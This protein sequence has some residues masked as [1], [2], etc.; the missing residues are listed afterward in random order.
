M[1]KG[2]LI[3]PCLCQEGS[4]QPQSSSFNVLAQSRFF[5]SLCM[6]SVWLLP[7][8]S[9]LFLSFSS[10][11][12]RHTTLTT[13]TMHYLCTTYLSHLHLKFEADYRIRLMDHSDIDGFI[14]HRVKTSAY[15]HRYFLSFG[16][17]DSWWYPKSL[18]ARKRLPRTNMRTSKPKRRR[19]MLNPTLITGT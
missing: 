19:R 7:L 18:V 10:S 11:I 16:S 17:G 12:L 14:I 1:V 8:L 3:Y 6:V 13:V 5:F 15:A 9:Y 4:D 2:Y